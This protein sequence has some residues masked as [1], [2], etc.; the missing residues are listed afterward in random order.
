MNRDRLRSLGEA[1]CYVAIMKADGHVSRRERLRGPLHARRS[2]ERLAVFGANKL[3]ARMVGTD[4]TAILDDSSF[5]T[6]DAER[7]LNE[8]IELLRRAARAGSRGVDIAADKL[9][10]ELYELAYLDG[11]DLR[12]SRFVKRTVERLRELEQPG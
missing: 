7:H 3:L 2:H 10:T 1:H 12:E 8:G 11:Y 5:E 4:I 6:W 9:E